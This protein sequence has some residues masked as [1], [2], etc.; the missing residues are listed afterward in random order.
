MALDLPHGIS[1]MDT[2][3][4]GHN[5]R[6][7]TPFSR[8]DIHKFSF[9]PTTNRLWNSLPDLIVNM[10]SPEAFHKPANH[11]LSKLFLYSITYLL[12][13]ASRHKYQLQL[14][15]IHTS[16]LPRTQPAMALLTHKLSSS[17]PCY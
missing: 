17:T 12:Y 11:F 3:T 14:P 1:V 2:V 6:Y 16:L 7:K 13:L 8:I 10:D 15:L 5:R 9:F 4:R